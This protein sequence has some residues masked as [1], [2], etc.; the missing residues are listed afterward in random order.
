MATRRQGRFSSGPE[1]KPVKVVP[2]RYRILPVEREFDNLDMLRSELN[3]EHRLGKI[4]DDMYTM[5]CGV[6]EKR[7]A[8]MTSRRAALTGEYV[9]TDYDA[10]PFSQDIPVRPLGL[11][12]ARLFQLGL[13]LLVTIWMMA[14]NGMFS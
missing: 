7:R 12:N 13:G 6:L 3:R 14:T 8:N 11:S 9:G 5:M 4:D 2:L 1:I 10:M